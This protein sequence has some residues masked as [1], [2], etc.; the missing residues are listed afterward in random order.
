MLRKLLNRK[1]LADHTPA[2]YEPAGIGYEIVT[3]EAGTGMLSG[4]Q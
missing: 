2:P 3:A 1:H 4:V